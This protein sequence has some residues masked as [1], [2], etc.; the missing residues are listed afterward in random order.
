MSASYLSAFN[1]LILKFNDDLIKVFPEENDFKVYKRGIEF[2]IKNNAKKVC[3]LFKINTFNYRKQILDKDE[4]FFLKDASYSDVVNT[5]DE[6]IILVINKLKN[7]WGDL[8]LENQT[9]IWEY[10]NSLIKLGDLVN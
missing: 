3:N 6:G 1:N 10:I 2:L 7:Y 8:S 5:K 9:K 4:S